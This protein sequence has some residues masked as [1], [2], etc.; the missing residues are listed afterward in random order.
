MIGEKAATLIRGSQCNSREPHPQQ[1][2]ADMRAMDWA[3]PAYPGVH[4]S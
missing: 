2:P 1:E 3:A 4:I